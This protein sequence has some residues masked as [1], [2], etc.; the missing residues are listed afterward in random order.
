MSSRVTDRP[1]RARVWSRFSDTRG[2]SHARIEHSCSHCFYENFVD[3]DYPCPKIF[4]HPIV[5]CIVFVSL[6]PFPMKMEIIAAR[7]VFKR[8]T[9]PSLRHGNIWRAIKSLLGI[10]FCRLKIIWLFV[11]VFFR[12]CA[13]RTTLLQVDQKT[14]PLERR[15]VGTEG[16]A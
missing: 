13:Y 4:G 7:A 10:G 11:P 3:W 9:L 2:I 16:V 14:R 6:F 1:G 8:R 12:R 15:D 5:R